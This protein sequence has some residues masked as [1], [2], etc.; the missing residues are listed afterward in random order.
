MRKE[1]DENIIDV[2]EFV[3]LS[4]YIGFIVMW[5]VACCA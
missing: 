3:L 5:V 4:G 1:T 2:T